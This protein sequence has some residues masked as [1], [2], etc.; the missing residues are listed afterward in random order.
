MLLDSMICIDIFDVILCKVVRQFLDVNHSLRNLELVVIDTMLSILSDTQLFIE[1]RN[2][3]FKFRHNRVCLV[4]ECLGNRV[5]KKKIGK[6][7]NNFVKVLS[8]W[9]LAF[10]RSEN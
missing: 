10:S 1:A 3:V 8:Q 9:A 6:Y 7:S 2:A 4:Y 5:C